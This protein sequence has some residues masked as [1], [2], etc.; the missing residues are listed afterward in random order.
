MIKLTHE[1][2][3]TLV[4]KI[5]AKI[6]KNGDIPKIRN[7]FGIP[8]GGYPIAITLGM[9]LD[10][11]VLTDESRVLKDTLIVDDL[12]DSG[13][14]ISK[15]KDNKKAVVFVK[16]NKKKLVDYYADEIDEWVQ[17]P[18]EPDDEVQEHITRVMQYIGEDTSREGLLE[19]PKRVQKAI[20]EIFAGYKQNPKDLM[21]T[22]TQG[23]CEEMVILKNCEFY[24]T[25]EHHMFP[26]FGHISIGYIPNKKVIGVS[27]LAR[28][29]DLFAKRMQIQERMTS[30]IA[31]TLMKELDALGV[32]V[33]C[34]GVHFCMRSR[35]VKK[36]DASMITSAVR[37][38]FKK[39]AKA[40]QEF[41]TL[42]KD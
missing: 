9:M 26:F 12:V 25:C 23:T 35:G 17:F 6:Q 34:E 5:A 1:E 37:G 16:H 33:V 24:S 10:K 31:D 36:Q 30:Q 4:A 29:A 19:T 42:I 13:K 18:D 28:L 38:I 2:L 41:L 20:D 39:D 27:K 15:Y 32:Y 22:F 3:E 7:I 11:P 8:R 14:T 21:K 40:R